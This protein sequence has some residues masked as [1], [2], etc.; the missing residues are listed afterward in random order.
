MRIAELE[1][2]AAER[3]D[4]IELLDTQAK[5]ATLAADERLALISR[6][7]EQLKAMTLAADE[8]LSQLQAAMNG[9]R[10]LPPNPR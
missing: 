9:S 6:I 4:L 3:L 5:A 1:T 8:R 2:T 10:V 7:D